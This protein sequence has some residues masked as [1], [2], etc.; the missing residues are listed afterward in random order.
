M[1]KG[2][3]IL[4][5]A[6]DREDA[7]SNV[8]SF[9]EPYGDSKVW[10][11]YTIG[12]RW[13]NTLAPKKLVE[14][15]DKW[16]KEEYKDVF[17]ERG[18]Y[19]VKDLENDKVRKHIQSKWESLGLKGKNIYYSAY[20]FDVNDT[21]ADYNI[22][23]LKDCLD[24]VKEWCKD[25]EVEKTKLWNELLEAKEKADNGEWDMTAYIAGKYR[26]AAYGNFCF[27]SNVFDATTYDA[28]QIPSNVEGYYAVMVDMHN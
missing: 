14:E 21:D 11:Y 10:D 15:F 28:E 6:Q 22:V 23:P 8:E 16:V 4:T 19:R 24:I 1:H 3:I 25:L 26:D 12:G 17:S 7:E 13:H 27:D 5:E 18:M 2:V 9:L 20:G